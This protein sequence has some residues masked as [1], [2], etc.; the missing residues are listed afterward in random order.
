MMLA[1]RKSLEARCD[2]FI[3]DGD[4]RDAVRPYGHYRL[5][6]PLVIK[7]HP[8]SGCSSSLLRNLAR[9]ISGSHSWSGQESVSWAC[10]RRIPVPCCM[11]AAGLC[12][13]SSALGV[14][15]RWDLRVCS[16]IAAGR[17]TGRWVGSPHEGL[18]DDLQK[19]ISS[20]EDAEA[21]LTLGT[22]SAFTPGRFVLPVSCAFPASLSSVGR[23]I[24]P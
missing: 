12:G 11:V 17:G 5:Y 13:C 22:A 6:Q 10:P 19:R 24:V 15:Y 16:K 20:P 1:R 8:C 2:Q 14:R 7:T 23:R 9:P 4:M 3:R 21:C 18:C